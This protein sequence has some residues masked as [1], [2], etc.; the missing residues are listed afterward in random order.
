[1]AHR[2]HGGE[3]PAVAGILLDDGLHLGAVQQQVQVFGELA[4]QIHIGA[5]G[6]VA[7]GG[8]VPVLTGLHVGV[9]EEG[10]AHP[11]GAHHIEVLHIAAGRQ[12]HDET[13]DLVVALVHLQ[14]IVIVVQLLGGELAGQSGGR[15][16]GQL[17]VEIGGPALVRPIADEHGRSAQSHSHGHDHDHGLLAQGDPQ[18]S[19]HTVPPPL[20]L[21]GQT[22]TTRVLN[23]AY[24][25]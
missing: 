24:R 18:L 23:P 21:C 11:V 4:H 14:G 6:A 17:G 10:D 12:I 1:M 25:R 7:A 13:L 2:R 5:Q 20:I 3:E 16:V 15:I 22:R 19:F 9:E 8:V